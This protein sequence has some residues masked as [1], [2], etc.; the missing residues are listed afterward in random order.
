M[1]NIV[2]HCWTIG[3]H[4][5]SPRSWMG[6]VLVRPGTTM[7]GQ[8]TQSK[9]EVT[10]PYKTSYWWATESHQKGSGLS[11][12]GRTFPYE[13]LCFITQISFRDAPKGQIHSFVMF[14]T[15]FFCLQLLSKS[16]ISIQ[17]HPI[18]SRC[19]CGCPFAM[20]PICP[21]WSLKSYPVPP[22]IDRDRPLKRFLRG[23]ASRPWCFSS[24][25]P[26]RNRFRCENDMPRW[27]NMHYKGFIRFL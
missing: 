23:K 18:I 13:S 12:S 19:R 6:M 7:I 15:C 25:R 14:R 5:N 26:C 8:V 24:C 10:K 1:L 17:M 20:L 3:N 22:W 4:P 16:I 2:E 21:P 9:S 11:A 27:S